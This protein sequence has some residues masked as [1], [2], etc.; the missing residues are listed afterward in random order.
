MGF[1]DLFKKSND[2]FDGT[3][4]KVC[5]GKFNQ[6]FEYSYE[7]Q[8]DKRKKPETRNTTSSRIVT[9]TKDFLL[10][11]YVVTQK[12]WKTIM[13]EGFN[14]SKFRGDDLPVTNVSFD[15]IMEFI[16]KLNKLTGKKYRLPTEAEWQWAAMGASKDKDQGRYAGC[17]EEKDLPK[18]AWYSENANDTIHPV[19]KKAAN[20]LGLYDMSGNVW[21]IC[22]DMYVP[23]AERIEWRNKDVVDPIEKK[24]TRHVLKGGC[25]SLWDKSSR[26]Y[27]ARDAPNG[28]GWATGFRLALDL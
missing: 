19:G 18:Y 15:E 3:M 27:T 8:P 21:E 9:I 5:A 12:Q 10:C 13:G 14:M 2:P 6:S 7:Y 24:G 22:Q 28:G 4:V 16:K 26:I 23:Y 20:E 25:C 11:K 1:L 17:N